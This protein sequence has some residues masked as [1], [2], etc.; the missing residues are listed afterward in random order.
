M[1]ILNQT[2]VLDLDPEDFKSKQ[3]SLLRCLCSD[4]SNEELYLNMFVVLEGCIKMPHIRELL[5]EEDLIGMLTDGV[6]STNDVRATESARALSLLVRQFEDHVKLE[7]CP[8]DQVAE[9]P[10]V[11]H[12]V[13]LIPKVVEGVNV[14]GEE[15]D[16]TYG[17]TSPILGR[18][19]L[20]M[21]TMLQDMAELNVKQI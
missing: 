15:M 7:A 5:M 10:V 14:D 19:R 6:L 18:R 12:L 13:V 16:A 11:G 4:N 2:S 20:T 8:V 21:M 3:R 17:R 1:R 9:L